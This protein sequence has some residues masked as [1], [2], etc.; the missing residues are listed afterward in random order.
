MSDI[1]KPSNRVLLH[2]LKHNPRDG[3]VYITWGGETFV[4]SMS[5]CEVTRNVDEPARFSIS[6]YIC[7][8]R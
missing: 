4:G 3:E 6:G 7:D 8:N 5:M 2:I 1:S